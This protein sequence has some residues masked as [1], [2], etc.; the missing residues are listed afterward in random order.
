LLKVWTQNSDLLL[1]R[2]RLLYQDL[3]DKYLLG[4]RYVIIL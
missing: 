1:V 4:I 2:L 3:F